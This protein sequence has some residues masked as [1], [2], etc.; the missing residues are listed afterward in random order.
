MAAIVQ[1]R[2]MHRENGL[3]E[4]DWLGGA[5]KRNIPVFGPSENGLSGMGYEHTVINPVS[6]SYISEAKWLCHSSRSLY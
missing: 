5:G 2:D 4:E 6:L 1:C 3:Q